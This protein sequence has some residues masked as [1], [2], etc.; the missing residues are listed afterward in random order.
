MTELMI[1][2]DMIETLISSEEIEKRVLEIS[3][4]LANEYKDKI[5]VVIGILKGSFVFMADLLRE[6]KFPLEIDFM[7][8]S[9]YGD[10]SKST[11]KLNIK[12][13]IDINI[14][15]RHI[16]LIEDIIDTGLTMS[17]LIELLNERK[18][19]SI[20]IVSLL[21]KKDC[22]RHEINVDYVGFS[23]PNEFVVGYGL[24]YAEKYRNLP[25]VGIVREWSLK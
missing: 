2:E 6:L 24:D 1:Q 19:A 20:K 18:P 21:D 3:R 13:E 9:S 25:Y 8:V 11:G 17:K 14:K 5:P 16:I 12:K 4:E 15:G 10:D 22:R 7:M 23:I